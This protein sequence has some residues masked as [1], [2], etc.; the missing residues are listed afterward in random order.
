MTKI[1][2]TIE[3]KLITGTNQ[4]FNLCEWDYTNRLTEIQFITKDGSTR[5]IYQKTA[6]VY[7]KENYGDQPAPANTSY[8]KCP[9]CQH[10]RSLICNGCARNDTLLGSL[11]PSTPDR[12]IPKKNFLDED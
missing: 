6:L 4:H 1:I 10:F 11:D 2:N 7:L 5:M 9:D 3:I 12:W 8:Y